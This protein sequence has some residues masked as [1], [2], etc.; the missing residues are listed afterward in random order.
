M[1]SFTLLAP[2]AFAAGLS[3]AC[4]S[5]GG[6]GGPCTPGAAG[7]DTGGNI[8]QSRAPAAMVCAIRGVVHVNATPTDAYE[9]F[10]S[11]EAS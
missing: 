3:G 8:F 5:S 4:G 10:R 6:S 11:L 9:L 1:K 7:V 2:I